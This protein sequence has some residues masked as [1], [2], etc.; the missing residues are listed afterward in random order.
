MCG[1]ASPQVTLCLSQPGSNR[2]GEQVQGT[3]HAFRGDASARES[4]SM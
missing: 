3:R 1:P 2:L 4:S